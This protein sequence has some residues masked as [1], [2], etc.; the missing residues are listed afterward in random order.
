MNCFCKDQN[1]QKEM[2]EVFKTTKDV[3]PIEVYYDE[4]QY[5]D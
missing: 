4:S 1:Y 2:Q 5:I 3:P